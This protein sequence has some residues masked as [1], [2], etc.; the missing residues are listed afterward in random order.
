MTKPI[1]VSHTQITTGTH[2]RPILTASACDIS[3]TSTSCKTNPGLP[4]THITTRRRPVPDREIIC[5]PS[6]STHTPQKKCRPPTHARTHSHHYPHHRPVSNSEVL[7]EVAQDERKGDECHQVQH[8]CRNS[9]PC[10]PHRGQAQRNTHL[11]CS[12]VQAPCVRAW[13]RAG[14]VWECAPHNTC[15]GVHGNCLMRIFGARD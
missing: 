5:V 6:M 1:P 4:D 15:V 3:R 12:A 9:S 7:C 10:H 2:R 11:Q 8:E 13:S 14:E